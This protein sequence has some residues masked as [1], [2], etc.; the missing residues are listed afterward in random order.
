MPVKDFCDSTAIVGIGYSRSPSAPGGGFSRAS[1]ETVLT[2]VTRAAREACRDAGLDP[3]ELDSSVAYSVNDSV[4]L[5]EVLQSLGASR[6][7]H[8]VNMTGGGNY[9]S[10]S[11]A[12]GAQAVHSGMASYCLVYRGMN[13]RSGVRMGQ[14]GGGAGGGTGRVGGDGQLRTIYGLAGPP[15]TYAFM[16]RRWMDRYGVESAD[17]GRFGVKVRA[18]A[19]KNP[20]AMMRDIYS[21]DDHQNSR[22]V[23][24]PYHLLDCCLETD[25]ACAMIITTKERAAA[26]RQTP[27]HISAGIGGPS[28]LDDL[29]DTNVKMIRDELFGAADITVQDIDVAMLYD[30][31]TD[32]PMRMIEEIGWCG[33]GEAKDWVTEDHMS[34]DG[35]IPLQ[36]SG[37]LMNEG[38]CHGLNNA[39]ELV[40]QLRGQAED[41]CPDWQDGVHTYDCTICRQV[42]DPE[43]GLHAAVLS[44][45]A[46]VLR[47]A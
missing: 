9:S 14:L 43:I 8:D 26:L 3:A 38:Y 19:N 10:L 24:D 21:L 46:V 4:G 45:S 30:N 44:K 40:Q 1:G 17:L 42:R 2:L 31:Y 25:V 22:W 47:K 29:L 16:A 11:I 7:R 34:L 39:L 18:N 15:S 27:V 33:P 37:G 32:C 5:Q 20:R 41:L 36:T 28:P 23:I 6:I 13:G 12:L 35:S